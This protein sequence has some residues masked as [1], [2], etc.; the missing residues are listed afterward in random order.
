MLKRRGFLTG[1][2]AAMAAPAIVRIDSI[3]PVRTPSLW[4]P[5]HLSGIGFP[6][7]AMPIGSTWAQTGGIVTAEWIVGRDGV[8]QLAKPTVIRVSYDLEHVVLPT[9]D[10]PGA[11]DV[12]DTD[13]FL[14]RMKRTQ[15]AQAALMDVQAPA[16][17]PVTFRDADDLAED[18]RP[19]SD[20]TAPPRADFEEWDDAPLPGLGPP[21]PDFAAQDV[22]DQL[23]CQNELAYQRLRNAEI[24]RRTRDRIRERRQTA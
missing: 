17:I 16:I 9:A 19:R 14:S 10:P 5:Q 22:R 13:A 18:T 4:R 23:Y 11:A 12:E 7:R 8:W 6:N 15:R 1:L 2:A 24:L 21:V 3:M 20:G